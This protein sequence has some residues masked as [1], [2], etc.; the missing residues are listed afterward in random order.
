MKK[1]FV[2]ILAA[3]M[4]GGAVTVGASTVVEMDLKIHLLGDVSGDG[5]ISAL[6]KKIIYN[7]INKNPE[8]TDEYIKS[9]G[10]VNKDGKIS[11]VDKKMIYNHINKFNSG[12][13]LWSK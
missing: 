1:V 2:A 7:H 12:G 5:K 3:L 10:D 9:V 11:A 6:D 4:L 8:I 13:S